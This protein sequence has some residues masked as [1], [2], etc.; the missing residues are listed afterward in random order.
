[1]TC[2]FVFQPSAPE[3]LNDSSGRKSTE[4]AETPPLCAQ[5]SAWMCTDK[6]LIGH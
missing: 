3:S 4:D 1:M 6:V 2:V 5:Q